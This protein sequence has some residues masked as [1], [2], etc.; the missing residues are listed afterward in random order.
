MSQTAVFIILES[1][2]ESITVVGTNRAPDDD[3]IKD[4]AKNNEMSGNIVASFEWYE[5]GEGESGT[6]TFFDD[7]ALLEMYG[8]DGF[9]FEEKC[10]KKGYESCHI[11]TGGISVLLD[12]ND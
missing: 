6:D 3:D 11:Q 8:D 10:E 5:I 9:D 12:E 7:K 1:D 2:S 4:L